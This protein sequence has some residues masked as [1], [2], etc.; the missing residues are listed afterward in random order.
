MNAERIAVK[1]NKIRHAG[2]R[3]FAITVRHLTLVPMALKAAA[4]PAPVSTGCSPPA[5]S[6]HQVEKILQ[7]LG[8]SR[9]KFVENSIEYGNT[10][11]ASIPIALDE[12]AGA[13]RCRIQPGQNCAALRPGAGSR[14]GAAIVRM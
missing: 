9:R 8:Y 10:G 5:N 11:A 13:R 14:L 2:A 6:Q 1:R 4:P 12:A 3:A 7:R